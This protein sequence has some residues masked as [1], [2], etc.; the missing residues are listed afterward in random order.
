[1][2]IYTN[3]QSILKKMDELR[4]Y[5]VEREP[6]MIMITETWTNETIDDNFLKIKGYEMVARNDREDTAGGRGGGILV[7]AKKELNCWK[8]GGEN[9]FTQHVSVRV[10]WEKQVEMSMHCVYRSPNS[11]R[12]NDEALCK[13]IGSLQGNRMII[14]DFN[15]PVILWEEGRSDAKG[16]GFFQACNDTF[17]EQQVKEATH[18]SGNRLDLVLT[19][20]SD[21]VIEVK[22]DG[23]IDRS[24]H[25]IVAIK[26]ARST[27]SRDGNQQYRNFSRGKYEVARAKI[28]KIEWD[29]ELEGKMS[30]KCGRV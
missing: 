22:T 23:R 18:I 19:D 13:W 2:V 10:K 30:K 28:A 21:R 15:L 4:S 27:M 9:E 7:Y 29:R 16:R 17:L 24:D 11:S 12:Q 25:E 20:R 5:I 3:A 6:E 26:L 14:G 8:E 1:M